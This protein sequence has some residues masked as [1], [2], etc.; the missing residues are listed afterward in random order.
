MSDPF[1]I[2]PDVSELAAHEIFTTWDALPEHVRGAL[3][4]A[5]YEI[6]IAQRF[7][8][9]YPELAEEQA[10]GHPEGTAWKNLEGHCSGARRRVAIFQQYLVGD[11]YVDSTRLAGV[12]RHEVG[13]AY[14]FALDISKSAMFQDA[15][16]N[17]T[18]S[19]DASP[20]FLQDDRAGQAETF[21]EIFAQQLGG[22]SGGDI[23]GEWPGVDA[24]VA[25][26]LAEGPE[27]KI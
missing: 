23:R 27:A 12:L 1:I 22:G 17:D 6:V 13:H 15:W 14:D 18:C 11:H 4:A 21:A 19:G 24:V 16:L 26:I 25:R 20:Y 7:A 5:D 8:D 9:A 3:A 10:P 2:G